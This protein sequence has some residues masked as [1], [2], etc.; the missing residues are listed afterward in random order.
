M[1]NWIFLTEDDSK[2]EIVI[3]ASKEAGSYLRVYG[4]DQNGKLKNRRPPEYKTIPNVDAFSLTNRILPIR[5]MIRKNQ[6]TPRTNI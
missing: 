2:A 1:G 4:L 3:N 6:L 5:K